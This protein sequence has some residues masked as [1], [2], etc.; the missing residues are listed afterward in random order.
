[1]K[2]NIN[3]YSYLLVFCKHLAGGE[4]HD[5]AAHRGEHPH[6]EAGE[7]DDGGAETRG[8]EQRPRDGH[9]GWE[10]QTCKRCLT[11]SR[12]MRPLA[13]QTSMTGLRCMQ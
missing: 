9:L 13:S 6:L 7:R 11:R 2:R 4:S 1:M 12:P 10:C 5:A 3:Y 8:H